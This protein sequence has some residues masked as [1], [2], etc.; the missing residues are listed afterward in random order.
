L[1]P[2]A[3]GRRRVKAAARQVGESIKAAAARQVG[4]SV[5]AAA[6]RQIVTTKIIGNPVNNE[7]IPNIITIPADRPAL[8]VDVSLKILSCHIYVRVSQ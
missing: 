6:A 5:K 1:A 8:E 4:E 3:P 2:A 7:A